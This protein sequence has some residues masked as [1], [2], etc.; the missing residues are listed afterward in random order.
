MES[1]SFASDYMII[2]TFSDPYDTRTHFQ[3]K[4]YS[5]S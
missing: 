1:E 2:Y 3:R 4:F 5:Y